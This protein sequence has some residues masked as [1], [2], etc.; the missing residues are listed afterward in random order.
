MQKHPEYQYLELLKDIMEN[1]SDKQLFFTPEVLQQYKDKDEEPPF[2]RS[3]FGRS[4]RFIL[5]A[6]F[7]EIR[8]ITDAT[9]ASFLIDISMGIFPFKCLKGSPQSVSF[10]V[11]L[12]SIQALSQR[13]AE[14]KLWNPFTDLSLPCR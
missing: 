4:H 10:F 8:S 14:R 6:F 11:L 2:I 12:R 9:R 7:R 13:S 1:G 5:G 3:V